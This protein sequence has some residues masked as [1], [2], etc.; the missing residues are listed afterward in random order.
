MRVREL[1]SILYASLVR[2]HL[3]L[4]LLFQYKHVPPAHV[5]ST[6]PVYAQRAFLKFPFPFK[7]GQL[8]TVPQ[9]QVT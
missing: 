9:V 8:L 4:G 2:Y 6:A 1:E 5:S 7:S 3:K